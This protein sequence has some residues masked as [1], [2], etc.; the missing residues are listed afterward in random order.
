[1]SERKIQVWF[2]PDQAELVVDCLNY[3]KARSE[4]R[5]NLDSGAAVLAKRFA[6]RRIDE[7]VAM[8]KPKTKP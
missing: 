1:M 8:F 6:I 3:V 7:I 5:N 2:R 4:E